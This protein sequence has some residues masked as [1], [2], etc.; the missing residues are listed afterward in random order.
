LDQNYPNPFNPT[1]TIEFG[2]PRAGTINLKIYDITGRET[3]SV[4]DNI[5]LGA[6]TYKY[7]FDG[8]TL[9]SGVYFYRL[10]ADGLTISSK[11]MVIIK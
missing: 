1:T 9:S 7:S 10:I 4:I 6:G 2:L 3:A 11:K 5:H 8:S